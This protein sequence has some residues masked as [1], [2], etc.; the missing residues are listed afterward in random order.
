MYKIYIGNHKTFNKQEI[1]KEL[2][3]YG[4]Q[5]VDR[6]EDA[7][8]CLL[9]QGHMVPEDS[10]AKEQPHIM[11]LKADASDL[12][13]SGATLL[14]D[15]CCVAGLK[16]YYRSEWDVP[17][18]NGRHHCFIL[19]GKQNGIGNTPS[20]PVYP[21]I[22]FIHN[23]CHLK[24]AGGKAREI[25]ANGGIQPR[26]GG[27]VFRGTVEYNEELTKHRMDCLKI[28]GGSPG[29]KLGKR[30]YIE[31][32]AK[33]LYI[34]S[35]WGWGEACWREWEGI[36]C[37]CAVIKPES[38]WCESITEIYKSERI[39]WCEPDW[40]DIEDAIERAI[41]MPKD[42]KMDNLEWALRELESGYK[43]IA[44]CIYNVFKGEV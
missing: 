10:K 29:R 11:V 1:I 41:A 43:R 36:L 23:P 26:T 15:P 4:V 2:S 24:E 39:I 16:G 27:S 7:D 33:R 20:K 14:K 3:E 31:D 28:F 37:G 34:P 44:E 25:L 30:A 38:R 18:H 5:H 12:Y 42:Q 32:T 40:S 35:P 21:W 13:S 6:E 8:L 22:E 17:I 9:F 19:S